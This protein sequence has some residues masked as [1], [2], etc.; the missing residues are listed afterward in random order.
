MLEVDNIY[1]LIRF[2][3]FSQCNFQG[4]GTTFT[5]SVNMLVLEFSEKG[6]FFKV[7]LVTDNQMTADT[8]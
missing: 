5:I 3:Q 4:G 1:T 2:Q 6:A 8:Y 7:R